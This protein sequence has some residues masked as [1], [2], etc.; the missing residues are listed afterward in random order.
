MGT[1]EGLPYQTFT[2][3]GKT[4]VPYKGKYV[5]G[6]TQ[7]RPIKI[8]FLFNILLTVNLNIFIS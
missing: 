6:F 2:N 7:S 3:Y 1:S 8:S 5:Y 4:I